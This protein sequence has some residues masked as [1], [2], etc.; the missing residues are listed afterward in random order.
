MGF[1]SPKP[2]HGFHEISP[3]YI[4]Y[5]ILYCT[6]TE[7]DVETLE[8]SGNQMVN[9]MYVSS[10]EGNH[11]D[12]HMGQLAS[13]AFVESKYKHCLYF[14]EAAY[15]EQM[16]LRAMIRFAET[17][18]PDE[19]KEPSTEEL[20]Q[21]ALG[22]NK[23]ARLEHEEEQPEEESQNT[24]NTEQDGH[25]QDV[26]SPNHRPSRAK[27]TS[28]AGSGVRRHKSLDESN[29]GTP[30]G[31]RRSL[32]RTSTTTEE[33]PLH[34]R[35]GRRTRR[36]TTTALPSPLALRPTRQPPPHHGRR[37]VRSSPAQVPRK[38]RGGSPI[39]RHSDRG[40]MRK[41][42]SDRD[43]MQKQHSDKGGLKKQHSDRDGMQKQHSDK[44]GL[45]KQHS[46]RDGMQKQHSDRE[47]LKKQHSDR[48]GRHRGQPSGSD[49]LRKL[50]K[51]PTATTI[52]DVY[53]MSKQGFDDELDANEDS[54]NNSGH[55]LDDDDIDDELSASASE[56]ST[57]NISLSEDQQSVS[58]KSDTEDEAEAARRRRQTVAGL[59][60]LNN[61]SD[62]KDNK[63]KGATESEE[64]TKK[65]RRRQT[66]VDIMKKGGD[67][68]D[69]FIESA[70]APPMPKIALPSFVSG[71]QS[72]TATTRRVSAASNPLGSLVLGV[73]QPSNPSDSTP[74]QLAEKE[75]L[76]KLAASL[77]KK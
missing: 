55:Y 36:N 34:G 38:T 16:Q 45:K 2:P 68:P 61:A 69:A 49:T 64:A 71:A 13:A 52:K 3:A 74:S 40:A 19:V 9:A 63:K 6:G 58:S 30:S 35:Q 46:D 20:V 67:D 23:A 18:I 17:G 7:E 57:F 22:R 73:P 42:H 56:S 11:T 53:N 44:G 51:H 10:L 59:M 25:D 65:A 31:R 76:L 29:S 77:L 4:L 72:T 32:R 33:S 21:Q 5:T 43:G 24:H 47:G 26:A 39:K 12:Q 8:K 48:D 41:Q 50:Q 75:K 54:R 27:R 37:S 62:H 15:H 1:L 60:N 14:S 70:A 66:M 28:A